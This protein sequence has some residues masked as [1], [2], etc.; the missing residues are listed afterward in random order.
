MS[1]KKIDKRN[2]KLILFTYI[3]QQQHLHSIIIYIVE[4]VKM[5]KRCGGC[6]VHRVAESMI[7]ILAATQLMHTPSGTDER[8]IQTALLGDWMNNHT[9]QN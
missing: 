4:L 8:R 2:Q 1:I 3:E 5:K 9:L 7:H 6:T